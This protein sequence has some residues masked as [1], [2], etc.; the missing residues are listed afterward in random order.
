MTKCNVFVMLLLE[1]VRYKFTKCYL[2][3]IKLT[4]SRFLK[5]N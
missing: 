5:G 4:F 3:G 1:S 2:K